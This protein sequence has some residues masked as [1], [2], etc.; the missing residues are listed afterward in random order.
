MLKYRAVVH[1]CKRIV[2]CEKAIKKS[3][4]RV[5]TYLDN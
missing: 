3:V 4:A 2:C 1:Q 5:Y